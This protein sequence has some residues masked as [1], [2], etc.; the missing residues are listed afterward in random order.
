MMAPSAPTD[1][2]W[3]SDVTGAPDCV[4]DTAGAEMFKVIFL[5]L[6]G[7]RQCQF[8]TAV[9]DLSVTFCRKFLG[10]LA[11]CANPLVHDIR[12][13]DGHGLGILAPVRGQAGSVADGTV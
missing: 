3:A 1:F 9:E 10:P 11:L 8:S 4:V 7:F 6:V 12:D 2:E 13:L 5:L